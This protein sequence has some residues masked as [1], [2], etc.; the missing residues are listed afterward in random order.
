MSQVTLQSSTSSSAKVSHALKVLGEIQEKRDE[1]M[2]KMSI[3][4]VCQ[5]S[6]VENDSAAPSFDCFYAN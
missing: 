3:Q 1:E 4:A 6:D 5:D 2:T